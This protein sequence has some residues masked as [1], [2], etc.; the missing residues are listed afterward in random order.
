M[1]MPPES[2]LDLHKLGPHPFLTGIAAELELAVPAG[3]TD[4]R[5]PKKRTRFRAPL[6]PSGTIAGR[7][8][9]ACNATSFLRV[10]MKGKR[11]EAFLESDEKL[12]GIVSVLE[13]HD[14]V[15]GVAGDDHGA[16]GVA[17]APL[18]CP[19][20]QYIM[21]IDIGQQWGDH[22]SLHHSCFLFDDA[23]IFQDSGLE[24]FPAETP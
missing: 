18:M 14:G 17:A 4:M 16:L 8:A 13:A 9:P 22:C 3:T 11:G 12:F 21:H 10:E 1:P 7:K 2:V 20:V 5:E 19:E 15:I 23:V 6:P 24:P